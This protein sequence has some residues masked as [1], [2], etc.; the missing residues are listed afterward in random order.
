[1]AVTPS[2]PT[3]S[4]ARLPTRELAEETTPLTPESPLPQVTAPALTTVPLSQYLD[5]TT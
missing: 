1:M 3:E 4:L 5:L 2:E